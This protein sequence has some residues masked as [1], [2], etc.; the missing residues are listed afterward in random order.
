MWLWHDSGVF[1]HFGASSAPKILERP[2]TDQWLTLIMAR[3]TVEQLNSALDLLGLFV[4]ESLPTLLS[5]VDWNHAP[6]RARMQPICSP[7]VA[8]PSRLRF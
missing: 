2:P 7:C 4:Q 6:L 3:P 5:E 1:Q 8:R